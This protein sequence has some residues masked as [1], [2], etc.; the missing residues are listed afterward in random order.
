[1]AAL[2]LTALLCAAAPRAASSPLNDE[3]SKAAAIG[4]R[5]EAQGERLSIADEAYNRASFERQQLDLAAS[6]VEG[7]LRSMDATYEGLRAQLSRRARLMYMHPGA[8]MD[9][10]V[11]ARSFAELARARVLGGSVL[12][13]DSKLVDAAEGA[14][15]R[16]VERADRLQALRANLSDKQR[17]LATERASVAREFADQRALLAGVNAS[18]AKLIEAERARRL[19]AAAR[20]APASSPSA[21]VPVSATP[22]SRPAS[23]PPTA[24]PIPATAEASHAPAPN[25]RAGTAVTTAPAQIGKPYPWAA[26]GPNSFDCSGLTMYSWSAA[27][28]TMTHYA[29]AQFDEFP[30]VSQSELQ[31]GDLVFFGSP[32]HHVG[33]YEGSGT[34]IDAPETGENVRRDSIYRPDYAGASRP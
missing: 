12:A 16:L 20:S 34:M 10:L 7:E 27:G 15:R 31:P 33:I 6:S 25:P 29:A 4:A 13:A 2:F 24:Q 18:I 9:G 22:A 23:P 26:A 17:Q 32:I 11:G 28:V 21:S 5:I 8:A 14:R 19:A 30:H 1:M 3:R